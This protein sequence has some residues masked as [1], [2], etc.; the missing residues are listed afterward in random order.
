MAAVRGRTVASFG[1]LFGPYLVD[2]ATTAK[3][4]TAA[5]ADALISGRAILSD[6]EIGGK[7]IL[8]NTPLL[9]MALYWILRHGL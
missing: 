7:S 3:P 9:A 5:V 4:G 2:S 1:Q 6:T 8:S